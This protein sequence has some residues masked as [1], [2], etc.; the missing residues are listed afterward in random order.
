MFFFFQSCCLS[1]HFYV[2]PIQ[3]IHWYQRLLGYIKQT[4]KNT[5]SWHASGHANTLCDAPAPNNHFK[6]TKKAKKYLIKT[7]NSPFL[8]NETI[9]LII[10][11][12]LNQ[13]GQQKKNTLLC[14][15]TRALIMCVWLNKY[16]YMG[17]PSLNLYLRKYLLKEF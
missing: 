3:M 14:Q 9:Y 1:A 12:I 5:T 2:I 13:K 16:K 4:E 15:Q 6:Q 11:D 10:I 17:Y 7:T 8:R